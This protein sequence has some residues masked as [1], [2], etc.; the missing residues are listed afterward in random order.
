MSTHEHDRRSRAQAPDGAL[1]PGNTATGAPSSAQES[2][3]A[4][5]GFAPPKVP[6][7]PADPE[8]L[9]RGQRV[10]TPHDMEPGPKGHDTT[11]EEKR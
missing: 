1:S 5:F 6:R 8:S 4:E 3:P 2:W 10:A 7:S 9:V 11:E